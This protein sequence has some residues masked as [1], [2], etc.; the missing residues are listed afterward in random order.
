MC[1]LA[2]PAPAL[3]GPVQPARSLRALT[4][5]FAEFEPVAS[6][7]LDLTRFRVIY[8]FFSALGFAIVA[9]KMYQ[10]GLLP[11]TSADWVSLLP[12]HEPAHRAWAAASFF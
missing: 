10:L 7:G 5:S 12:T 9:Y 4:L 11:V 8:L 1:A 2:S 3:P 6:V